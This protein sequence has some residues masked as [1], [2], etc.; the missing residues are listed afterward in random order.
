M[1]SVPRKITFD[2]AAKIALALP[3]ATEGLRFRNRTWFVRD[4]GFAWERPFSKADV[5]RFGDTPVPAGE[6]L[7]VRTEDL[8]EKEAILAGATPGFFNIAHFDGYPAFL[9]QLSVV[10]RADLRAAIVDGWLAC[11][12]DDVA[13]AYLAKRRR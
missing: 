6:I 7:A 10:S 2:D 12:P 9:I 11:A 5:K 13:A 4:K 1:V 8:H 3:E